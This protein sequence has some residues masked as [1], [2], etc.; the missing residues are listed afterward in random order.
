[1][2]SFQADKLGINAKKQF[3]AVGKSTF[4]SP[5]PTFRPLDGYE[6]KLAH[7]I[8]AKFHEPLAE[9]LPNNLKPNFCVSKQYQAHSGNFS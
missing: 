4:F 9:K 2:E 7:P 1:M 6:K 5:R 3:S 8:I